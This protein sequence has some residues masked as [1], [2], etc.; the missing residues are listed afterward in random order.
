[1]DH[2]QGTRH[3][4]LLLGPPEI[5]ALGSGDSGS[6]SLS[7]MPLALFAYLVARGV[8]VRRDDLAR[9]FWPD[10]DPGR[11][12]HGLRQALSRVRRTL[13]SEAILG[14]DPVSANAALLETDLRD[15]EGILTSLTSPDG[16]ARALDLWRGPFLQGVGEMGSWELQDW[17]ETRRSELAARLADGARRSLATLIEHGDAASSRR[18]V[19][20]VVERIP[21]PEAL[22]LDLAQGLAR[23]GRS[24]EALHWLE[25]ADAVEDTERADAIRAEAED[26]Q[27]R[28]PAPQPSEAGVPSPETRPPVTPPGVEEPPTQPGKR[29]RSGRALLVT[30]A[31]LALLTLGTLGLMATEGPPRDTRI[32]FCS[33]RETTTN[34]TM[35]LR[36]DD[37]HEAVPEGGCPVIPVRG[38]DLALTLIASPGQVELRAVENGV[39]RALLVAPGL[40]FARPFRQAG[41]RDGIIDPSGRHLL[42]TVE[43][44]APVAGTAPG[45]AGS[46]AD[47]TR[48]WDLALLDL[49]DGWVENLGVPGARDFDGRF[50]PDG[51]AVVFAS[52]RTGAG[53]LYRY[54]LATGELERLTHDP[55]PERSPVVGRTGIAFVAGSGEDDPE[56]L[57]WLSFSTG[58]VTALEPT[59]WNRPTPDLSPDETRLCFTDKQQGHWESEIRILDIATGRS[60][61]FTR[62]AGRDD[63]C[64]W[65]DDRTVLFRSWRTGDEEIFRKRVGW[66]TRA[67]DLS[68]YG[69]DDENPVVVN[70]G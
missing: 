12:R 60:H 34:L 19:E 3:R 65:V 10:A 20:R 58:Q 6:E 16:M 7:G 11:A 21:D 70:G 9:L 46:S 22:L 25:R 50:T 56:Q 30:A 8:A 52:E 2:Q 45:V 35:D 36:G 26:A 39:P 5:R 33:R 13:G 28:M 47:D 29:T 14:Q 51:S 49:D 68:R 17:L 61:A 4:L 42:L 57:Q 59:D 63:Y 24:Q 23:L 43:R 62:S 32:W 69:V 54:T 44:S 15:L 64:V 27:R 41:P 67:V 31:V 18:L 37:K 38:R 48:D 55:R 40:F 66:F 1:M 53:D